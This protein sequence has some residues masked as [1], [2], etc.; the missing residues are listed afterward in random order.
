MV[1]LGENYGSSLEADVAPGEVATCF[2]GKL[3]EEK[4]EAGRTYTIACRLGQSFNL[5]APQDVRAESTELVTVPSIETE[6]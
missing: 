2:R 3:G 1:A 6:G 4:T 5:A